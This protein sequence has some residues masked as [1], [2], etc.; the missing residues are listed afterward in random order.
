[1]ADTVKTF[2]EELESSRE[3]FISGAQQI[4]DTV[5][6]KNTETTNTY[7]NDMNAVVD[8]NTQR[9]TEKVEKQIEAVPQQ[10]Q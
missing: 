9:A 6:G 7:I 10:Y 1:M 2:D 5:A 8:A 3:K 4:H